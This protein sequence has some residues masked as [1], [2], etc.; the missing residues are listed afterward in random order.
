MAKALRQ[1]R[2]RRCV[3]AWRQCWQDFL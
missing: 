1:Q 2:S 3:H